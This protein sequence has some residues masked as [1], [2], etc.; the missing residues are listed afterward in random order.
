MTLGRLAGAI[1]LPHPAMPG[2]PLTDA[3]L[4]DIVA[5]I[6]SLKPMN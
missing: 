4:R 6:A 5:Y 3:E 2:V 1:T